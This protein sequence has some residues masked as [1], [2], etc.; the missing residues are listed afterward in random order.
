[1]KT[2]DMSCKQVFG[3]VALAAAVAALVAAGVVFATKYFKKKGTKKYYI[4]CSD[5]QD[6]IPTGEEEDAEQ[7]I[8]E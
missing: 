8:I 3:I 4:E 7:A 6:L 1:M 2:K 5:E